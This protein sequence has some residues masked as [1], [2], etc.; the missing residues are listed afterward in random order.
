VAHADDGR[1]VLLLSLDPAHNQ[2]D[3]FEHRLGEEA[4]EMLPGLAVTEPDLDR[5]IRR[6]IAEVEERVQSTY[7]YLTT[8]NLEHHF[9]V[10]R[11][12]PGLE[13]FALRRLFEHALTTWDATDVI[14]ADM[15]PTALA[16]RFFASPTLSLTW[17]QQLLALRRDIR[18]RREMI[19]RIRIGKKEIEPDRVLRTLEAEE[20]RNEA[21]RALFS[22]ASRSAVQLIINPDP[23]SWNEGIRIRRALDPLGVSIRRCIVNK[24]VCRGDAIVPDELADLKRMTVPLVERSPIGLEGL[25]HILD[26]EAIEALLCW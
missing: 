4:A 12:S 19:T 1:T 9:R 5:W 11:H 3:I 20:Q 13:E 16:T 2:S 22:D 18:A 14:I 7:T 17:T 23:L 10:L 8:L 15:P 21:L 26:Q 25:R 6:Y 24:V